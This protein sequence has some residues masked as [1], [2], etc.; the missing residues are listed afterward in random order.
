MSDARGRGGPAIAGRA[1][2]ELRRRSEFAGARVV[3]GLGEPALFAITLS[4]VVAGLYVT[5]GVVRGTTIA[6]LAAQTGGIW[7]DCSV[8]TVSPLGRAR[9]WPNSRHLGI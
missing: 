4:A 9:T 6:P 5:V 7:P 3:R 8:P 2:E 1:R